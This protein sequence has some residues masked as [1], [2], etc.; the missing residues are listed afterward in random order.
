[1]LLV[2]DFPIEAGVEAGEIFAMREKKNKNLKNLFRH[3][4]ITSINIQST[5][6]KMIHT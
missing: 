5:V 2:F 6:E 1:M 4:T 3:T